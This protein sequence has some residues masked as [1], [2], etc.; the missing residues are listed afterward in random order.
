MTSRLK[1]H[2]NS[3]RPT[4]TNKRTSIIPRS[5]GGWGD[6]KFS[7]DNQK[8][9]CWETL[10][11]I[12]LEDHNVSWVNQLSMA[13]FINGCWIPSGNWLHSYWKWPIEIVDLHM[14]DGGFPQLCTRLPEVITS[15]FFF[16]TTS[17]SMLLYRAKRTFFCSWH[18]L[19]QSPKMCSMAI[20]DHYPLVNSQITKWKSTICHW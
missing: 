7:K 14:K 17:E 13:M 2:G 10:P 3:E 11:H 6:K 8:D 5:N 18:E 20:N 15:M 19:F 16:G 12:E 4:R 1:S 9:P